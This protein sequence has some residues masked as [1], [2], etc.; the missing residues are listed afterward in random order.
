MASKSDDTRGASAARELPLA[1]RPGGERSAGLLAAG[2]YFP[3]MS[4]PALEACSS[5]AEVPPLQPMA[6]M[7]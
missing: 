6:P 1:R 7:I 2:S 4:T 5:C 3:I